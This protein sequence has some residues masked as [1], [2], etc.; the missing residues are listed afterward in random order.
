MAQDRIL[1]TGATGFVGS[2]VAR[3]LAQ[4]GFS[5]RALVRRSSPRTHVADLGMELVEGDLRDADSVRQ[6]MAGSRFLFH[7]AAD[8]RLWARDPDEIF[9]NNV[10]G[11][12]TLMR[13]A[14]R[15]GIERIVYTSSVCTLALRPDRAPAD[16]TVS[17]REQ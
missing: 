10:L 7:V 2:A 3:R 6:A 12:R 17:L 11:T 16:E 8:Y 14:L 13:E 5:V 4:E 1:I 9:A 15:A